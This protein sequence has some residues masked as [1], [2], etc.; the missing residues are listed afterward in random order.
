MPTNDFNRDGVRRELVDSAEEHRSGLSAWRTRLARVFDPDNGVA[1]ADKRAALGLPDRRSFFLVGGAA[2]AASTV[3]VSCSNKRK[4]IQTGSTPSTAAA[5][6]TTAPGSQE[7]DVTLLRTAQSIEVLAI[8]TYKAMLDG[9]IVKDALITDA[10][11]LF[12]SQHRDHQQAVS[13]LVTLAGGE[14]Y[15]QANPYL[16]AQTVDPA[17]NA[18]TDPTSVLKLAV[19]I[20]NLAAQT[21]T[22]A[23]GVL[24]RP[25]LRQSAMAIGPSEARH[26]SVLYGMLETPQVPLPLMPTTG[27]APPKAYLPEPGAITS[28]TTTAPATPT[29][30]AAGGGGT[31]TTT[32]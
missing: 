32:K 23:G 28:T 18:L 29:T 3:L 30:K 10:F 1:D 7:M 26:M 25:A 14:P 11:K 27:A 12:Q 8:E 20:E 15:D 17:V 19:E 4:F 22:L 5:T 2:V 21:Y 31:T 24:T 16:K 6:T 13:K 9:G